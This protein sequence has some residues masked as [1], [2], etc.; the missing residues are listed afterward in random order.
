[1]YCMPCPTYDIFFL[2][3]NNSL[4]VIT[5]LETSHLEITAITCLHVLT[6]SEV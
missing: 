4:T 6:Y 1:M 3:P 5:R 2:C